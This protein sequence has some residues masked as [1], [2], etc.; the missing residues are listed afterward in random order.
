MSDITVVIPV[1]NVADFLQECLDSL[2]NDI[3]VVLVND[4]STDG[5]ELLCNEY[6]ANHPES[7]LI[8]K[9]NGGLS[10]ARNYGI[11]HVNSDYVF[12]LDSDDRIDGQ[13]LLCALKFAKDNQLDWLQCGYVY[14]YGD[15]HLTHK[16]ISHKP[17]LLEKSFVLSDL[18]EDGLIKNF[19]WGKIYKTSIVKR[20]LFPKG[21]FFEDI[22][23]QYKVI[24]QSEKFG[25]YPSIVSFYRS[26]Q[27]SISGTF[28]LKGLD[29]IEGHAE[30]LDFIIKSYPEL[31][32]KA[33]RALWHTAFQFTQIAQ[34]SLCNQESIQKYELA[35]SRIEESYSGLIEAGIK[36]ERMLIG[37]TDYYLYKGSRIRY[38]VL[39]MLNK[40]L[41]LISPSKYKTIKLR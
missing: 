20:Y 24:D 17:I 15:Y 11:K 25:Y 28:S 31:A 8:N 18:V 37:L 29:L 13:A 30:R 10:D 33:A 41:N 26:R 34:S 19:A 39:K 40:A 9:P 22:F 36:E 3:N 21:K 4:G 5:S 1:Y 12:F 7:M 27:D 14:D 38:C 2:P 35:Q 32:P 23:W 16:P 6:F